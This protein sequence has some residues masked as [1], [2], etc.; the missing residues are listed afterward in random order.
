MTE[1]ERVN[2]FATLAD[3]L[4]G[5]LDGAMLTNGLNSGNIIFIQQ[6]MGMENYLLYLHNSLYS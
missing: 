3:D 1:L 4:F 6:S 5:I 2:K